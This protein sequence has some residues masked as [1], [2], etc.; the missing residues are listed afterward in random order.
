MAAMPRAQP[1]IT[2]AAIKVTFELVSSPGPDAAAGSVVVDPIAAV[3][4]VEVN[5]VM[6]KWDGSAVTEEIPFRVD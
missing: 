6:V 3:V 1:G 2:V 4:A 5:P